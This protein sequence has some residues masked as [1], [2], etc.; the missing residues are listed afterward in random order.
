MEPNSDAMPAVPR[1]DEL[2]P[3]CTP[4]GT[5]PAAGHAP[6]IPIEPPELV[7]PPPPNELNKSPPPTTARRPCAQCGRR[8]GLQICKEV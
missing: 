1:A 5:P 3:L 7:Y 8:R 6:I 2:A 4:L